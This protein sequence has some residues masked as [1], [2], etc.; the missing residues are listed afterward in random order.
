[1]RDRLSVEICKLGKHGARLTDSVA[2]QQ[3]NR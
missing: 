3:H 1:M 2:A